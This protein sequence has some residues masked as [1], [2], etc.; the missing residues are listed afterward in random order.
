[1]VV[2]LLSYILLLTSF[3]GSKCLNDS[4]FIVSLDLVVKV[5][6]LGISTKDVPMDKLKSALTSISTARLPLTQEH[7]SFELNYDVGSAPVSYLHQFE[8]FLKENPI[9]SDSCIRVNME[10][11]LTFLEKWVHES[12]S[13]ASGFVEAPSLNSMTVVVLHSDSLPRHLIYNESPSSCV[14]SVFGSFAFLD[15]SAKA[16]PIS[17]PMSSSSGR[18]VEFHTPLFHH[19]WPGT[20]SQDEFTRWSPLPTSEIVSHRVSRVSAVVNSAVRAF[21]VANIPSTEFRDTEH[22][23][24]PL[25]YIHNGHNSDEID[26]PG[27]NSNDLHDWIQ[28]IVLPTQSVTILPVS[29]HAG[30]IASVSIAMSRS[31]RYKSSIAQLG[32]GLE[33][34]VEVPFIDPDVL[35]TEIQPSIDRIVS[36]LLQTAG[37]SPTYPT[38]PVV[39]LSDFH[40]RPES[41]QKGE[42]GH[43]QPLFA[44]KE[45]IYRAHSGAVL[46]LHSST[47]D[48][49]WFDRDDTTSVGSWAQM[50]SENL[51]CLVAAC[52]ARGV[53]NLQ[54]PHLQTTDSDGVIDATWMH[55]RHILGPFPADFQFV[56]W[57]RP[58]LLEMA[59]VRAL[60]IGKIERMLISTHNALEAASENLNKIDYLNSIPLLLEGEKVVLNQDLNFGQWKLLFSPK[61][62]ALIEVIKNDRANLVEHA[63]RIVNELKSKNK[64]LSEINEHIH[65]NSGFVRYL[66]NRLQ[67]SLSDF[68]SSL[69]RGQISFSDADSKN[70]NPAIRTYRPLSSGIIMFR[71]LLVVAI[72]ILFLFILMQ[73][74][75]FVEE[76]AK[77]ND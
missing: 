8:L 69:R 57:S 44:N 46:G 45:F 27:L 29:H 51:N 33:L 70:N 20:F 50:P 61:V 60:L 54:A 72:L 43:I 40:F 75:K 34:K 42:N 35:W 11:L 68:E 1:M 30:D 5:K 13:V 25:I 76:R 17:L 22:V 12:D 2:S 36:N 59:S 74:Q 77:K 49:K 3:V 15:M 71:G 19:P 14:Q 24:I 55:G 39:I 73:F 10:N 16:C 9:D 23:F 31:Q 58:G 66:A 37:L 63:A 62:E 47:K 53:S 56:A 52:V 48:V 28:R 7:A 65:S 21:S 18:H 67:L 4:E 32:S 6:L 64:S 41:A 38:T 26:T